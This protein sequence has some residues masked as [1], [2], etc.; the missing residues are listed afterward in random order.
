LA[1]LP[2]AYSPFL[3]EAMVRLGARLPFAQVAEEMAFLCGVSVSVDT[4]RRLTEQ[5]GA[6]QVAI[7]Q[8]EVERLE[9]QAPPEPTG[10]AVQQVSADGAMVPVRGGSW[11]EVRTSAIGTINEQ[12]GVDLTRF[13]GHLEAWGR[14]IPEG[15]VHDASSTIPARVSC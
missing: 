7:E 6:L 10:P 1:L 15:C 3:V 2:T 13:G 9:R 14:E 4:V 12:R 8:R 5:A 11:T